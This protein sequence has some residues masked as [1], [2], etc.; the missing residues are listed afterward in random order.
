MAYSTVIQFL[1]NTFSQFPG[2]GPKTAQRFVFYLLKKPK[3]ELENLALTIR[4]LAD[5]IK[6]CPNCFNLS[7][8]SLNLNNPKNLCSICTDF[9]RNRTVLCVVA[10][11]QDLEVIEKTNQYQGLY[12]VLGG[13]LNPLEGITPEKLRIKELIERI[14]KS[15]PKINEIILALDSNFEGETTILYLTKLLKPFKIRLTRLA[16]GL[17]MGSDLEYADEVTLSNAL[18]ERKEI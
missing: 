12:H 14:K 18:K 7:E 2:I 8:R 3:E 13:A 6:F 17:P 4:N 11:I 15:Q 5:K 10:E 16:C 9:K 1:I